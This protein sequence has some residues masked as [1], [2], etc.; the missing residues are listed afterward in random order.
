MHPNSQTG[1]ANE[2]RAAAHFAERGWEGFWPPT[3]KSPCDFVMV[4]NGDTHRVQ[5][6]TASRWEKSG[7]TY[8][9]CKLPT[10]YKPG[11]FDL[12]VAVA[13]D[14]RLWSIPESKLP[15]TQ[16]LYL[17]KCGGSARNYGWG[18]YEVTNEQP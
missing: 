9:R 14:G 11:A 18:I 5:V 12:L 13:K 17:E 15:K 1:S 6:K 3:G 10:S 16:T 7:S 4:R 2:Y 8:L